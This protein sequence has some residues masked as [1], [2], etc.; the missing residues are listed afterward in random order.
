MPWGCKVSGMHLT[1]RVRPALSAP[2]VLPPLAVGVSA[3]PVAATPVTVATRGDG[4]PATG[5]P[6]WVASIWP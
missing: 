4:G 2:S 5:H 6:E 3:R 1:T